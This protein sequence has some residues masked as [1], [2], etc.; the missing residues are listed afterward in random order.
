M[1][2]LEATSP[3]IYGFQVPRVCLNSNVIRFD[4]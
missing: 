2:D 1:E 3:Y 4:E